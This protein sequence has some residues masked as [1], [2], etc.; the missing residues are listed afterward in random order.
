M[1]AQPNERPAAERYDRR[2][3]WAPTQS[4]VHVRYN[5]DTKAPAQAP[6][7]R[8]NRALFPRCAVTSSGRWDEDGGNGISSEDNKHKKSFLALNKK[9][10]AKGWKIIVAF[11]YKTEWY[12]KLSLSN[13]KLTRNEDFIKYIK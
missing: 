10:I 12:D 3:L 5:C 6:A 13:L 4:P 1:Q 11:F 2:E 9:I 8:V 7:K